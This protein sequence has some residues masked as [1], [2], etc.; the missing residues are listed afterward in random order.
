MENENPIEEAKLIQSIEAND[1]LETIGKNTEASILV[2]D[3]TK[4]AVK[5]LQPALDAIALNT[6]PKEVQKVKIEIEEDEKEELASAFFSMLKG[7]KGDKGDKGD[8]PTKDELVSIITPLIPEPIKG[9]SGEDYVLTEKDKKEI[10]KSVKV[11]VVEKIIEKTEVIRETPVTIDKT[12]TIVKEVAKYETAD[13]IIEK[14]NT[15]SK[16][17]DW[18]T[19]K[20]FPDFSKNG[21]SGLNTVFTDGTTIIGNGLADNPLRAVG[22][23]GSGI[24]SIVAGT[25]ITVDNTDPLNPIVSSTGGG[26]IT[27]SGANTQIA[28]WTGATTQAGYNALSY[29]SATGRFQITDGVFPGPGRAFLVDAATYTVDMGDISSKSNRVGM[30]I[31]NPS[32][33]I[34]MYG[35][36]STAAK[37]RIFEAFTNTDILGAGLSIV[38]GD[39]DNSANGTQMQLIDQSGLFRVAGA[40]YR[41]LNLDFAS[42]SYGFADYTQTTSGGSNVGGIEI[43]AGGVFNMWGIDAT[44]TISPFLSLTGPGDITL[45]DLNGVGSAT[46]FSILESSGGIYDF[47]SRS[48]QIGGHTYKFPSTQAISGQALVAQDTNGTLLYENVQRNLF[49]QTQS[50]TVANTTTPTTITGTGEGSLLVRSGTAKVGSTYEL[51]F[52]GFYNATSSPTIS[53]K[54]KILGTNIGSSITNTIPGGGSSWDVRGHFKLT[55]LTTGASGT[56][57]LNGYITYDKNDG[58]SVTYPLNQ[59]AFQAINTTINQTT[60][61]VATWSAA[62]PLNSLTI[63][64]LTFNQ[65]R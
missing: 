22:G 43:A 39:I 42:E 31:N 36:D 56:A 34:T 2:Q 48:F 32:E 64:Q 14:L 49:A 53:Y 59:T 57:S 41:A 38:M 11:P 26:G 25:N 52:E 16:A 21:G 5:D 24:Q 12:K 30:T 7:K 13:E 29:N 61:F 63:R 62:D 55:V 19:I 40:N 3:E 46:T 60:D 15:L 27:G 28:V 23:G 33:T 54:L 51:D 10:A 44:S 45:G 47:T 4:E 20:N 1:K 6:E 35:Q 8:S 18:K 37:V 50:V 65:T 17:L 9:D 58:T